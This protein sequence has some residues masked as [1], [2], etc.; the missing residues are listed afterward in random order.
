[1]NVSR[2]PPCAKSWNGKLY[3]FGG[4]SGFNWTVVNSIEVYDPEED[5]WTLLTPSQSPRAIMGMTLYEN[6][7]L[8]FGGI[9][10]YSG[11]TYNYTS[12]ILSY[13]PSS[14]SWLSFHSPGD[15]IPAYR[16]AP[17]AV[18]A[19]EKV[20]LFGGYYDG[21][22]QNNVWA[23]SLKNIRQN[24]EIRDTLLSS[25]GIEIDLSKY[26][27]HTVEED[28][29]YGICQG[30][31]E[32]LIDASIENSILKIDWIAQDGG[33]TEISLIVYDNEDTISSNSFTVANT[34]GVQTYNESQAVVYPNPAS[35]QAVIKYSIE[36]AGNVSLEIY[37][38]TGQTIEQFIMENIEAGD[39][40]LEWSVE[41][42]CSGLYF[43][44]LK[45]SN[46][47]AICK[48]VI[49]H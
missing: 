41:D 20:L 2:R 23:Y 35:N 4:Y 28:L 13:N 3:A 19:D 47:T 26:F 11:S 9:T 17:V 6:Q 1:M 44:V 38:S 8:T 39:H 30:F 18:F 31:N 10:G 22:T 24:M 33:G 16:Q 45:T 7:L 36:K 5:H 46:S 48:L 15:N 42:Y 25:E 34:V 21:A 43:T 37:N 29:S 40:S 12:K 49:R 14:N 27:S 32:E